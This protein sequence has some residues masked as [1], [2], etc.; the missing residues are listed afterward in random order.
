MG[1]AITDWDSIGFV[2][3]RIPPPTSYPAAAL[4]TPCQ[5]DHNSDLGLAIAGF[6]PATLPELHMPRLHVGRDGWK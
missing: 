5:A 6:T 1:E 4:Q 3:Q 2:R